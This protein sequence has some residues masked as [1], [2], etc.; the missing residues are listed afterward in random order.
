LG[1][2]ELRDSECAGLPRSCA[3]RDMPGLTQAQPLDYAARAKCLERRDQ[4]GSRPAFV[5]ATPNST[6]G[7]HPSARGRLLVILN[8]RIP[9]SARQRRVSLLFQVF[10]FAQGT[11]QCEQMKKSDA[12]SSAATKNQ[13][14]KANFMPK[15]ITFA[16]DAPRGT[17]HKYCKFPL[18]P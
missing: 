16:I 9:L 4:S 12:R 6:A 2:L 8:G 3:P 18:F 7:W 11:L 10:H 13:R 5:R 1:A 17:P 15:I 14:C